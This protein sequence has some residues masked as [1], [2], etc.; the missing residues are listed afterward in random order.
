MADAILERKPHIMD[1]S[2]RCRKTHRYF[3]GAGWTTDQAQAAVYHNETEAARA[4]VTHHLSEIDL[5]LRPAGTRVEI[6][7]TQL[8]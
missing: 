5:V 2:I 6:F 3:T 4:C 7:A 1:R 8:R